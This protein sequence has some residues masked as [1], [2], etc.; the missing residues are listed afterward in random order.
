MLRQTKDKTLEY[1]QSPREP[2]S[3]ATRLYTLDRGSKRDYAYHIDLIL[4]VFKYLQISAKVIES[5]TWNSSS[6]L[7]GS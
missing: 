5:T 6:Y 3:S 7:G 1:T 4:N 2:R